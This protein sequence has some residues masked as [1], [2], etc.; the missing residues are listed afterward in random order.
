MSPSAILS[1][2]PRRTS[3]PAGP[4][5]GQ[6]RRRPGVRLAARTLR[7]PERVAADVSAGAAGAC[8]FPAGSFIGLDER[9]T[10]NGPLGNNGPRRGVFSSRT[11]PARARRQK[12]DM[13]TNA[14]SPVRRRTDGNGLPGLTVLAPV[15]TV[16]AGP[17]SHGV[18][19]Q[20]SVR[21]P[22]VRASILCHN[23]VA[24]GAGPTRR[25]KEESKCRLGL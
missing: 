16:W 12:G 7:R 14:E 20:R 1:A 4:G 25:I 2:A 21:R 8:G 6:R 22:P 23:P 11:G 5:R 9:D 3:V 17:V 19:H 13:R 10:A 18:S 24:A 15:S